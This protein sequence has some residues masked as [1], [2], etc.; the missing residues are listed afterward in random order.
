MIA[1]WSPA[2]GATIHLA[3]P[4]PWHLPA[5]RYQLEICGPDNVHLVNRM[6]EGHAVYGPDLVDALAAGLVTPIPAPD[7]ERDKL[8]L[9]LRL[10]A[11]LHGNRK[12][13]PVAQADSSGLAL[14]G[15]ADQPALF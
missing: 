5:A 12:R 6:G 8:E 10:S 9:A 2:H 3:A 15:N 4:N 13:A 14:F 7:V 1:P 11:P